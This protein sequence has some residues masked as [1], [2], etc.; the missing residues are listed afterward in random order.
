M[1]SEKIATKRQEINEAETQFKTLS[2]HVEAIKRK[3]QK[4]YFGKPQADVYAASRELQLAIL[5]GCP[6]IPQPLYPP[7]PG[8][9]W[10]ETLAGF[11]TEEQRAT[12]QEY[13]D[14]KPKIEQL[15]EV[16]AALSTL[17]NYSFFAGMET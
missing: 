13:N 2:S 8:E 5:P 11:V 7:Y 6:T 12:I 10:K 3:L 1:I 15:R 17:E 14:K 4:D 16:G 9:F